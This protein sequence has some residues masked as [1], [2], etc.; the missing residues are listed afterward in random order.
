[1]QSPTTMTR[2]LTMVGTIWK[3]LQVTQNEVLGIATGCPRMA[4]I[5]R[6][7]QEMNVLPFRTNCDLLTKQYML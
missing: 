1:M 3:H 4:S 7:H 6:L 2:W 5:D